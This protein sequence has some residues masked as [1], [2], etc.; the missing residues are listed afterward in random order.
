[1][2]SGGS[3][4]AFSEFELRVIEHSVG[5]MCRRRSPRE[6]ADQLR[7]VYDVDGHSVTIYE[8][9]PAWDD[10]SEWLHSPAARLRFFRSRGEWR[11]YWMRADMKWHAYDPDEMPADLASLVAVV[12]EDKYCAFFG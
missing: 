10:P 5:A 2:E 9:R 1:M 6:F 8:E 3:G 4:M 12:D 7:V 11:L